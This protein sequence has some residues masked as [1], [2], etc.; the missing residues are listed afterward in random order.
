[1]TDHGLA[2]FLQQ[3][4]EPLLRSNE[5]IDLRGL[6]IQ[7]ISDGALLRTGGKREGNSGQFLGRQM[8]HG[9]D[10]AVPP[11]E[12]GGAQGDQVVRK[13]SPIIISVRPDTVDRVL[14][15]PA[16]EVFTD[17]RGTSEAT[18]PALD[19]DDVTLTKGEVVQLTG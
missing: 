10:I 18:L 11:D 19:H 1:V 6:P 16:V 3:S 13:K 7:V 8:R 9:D 4:N 12:P 5:T 15:P 14:E 17:V 2:S